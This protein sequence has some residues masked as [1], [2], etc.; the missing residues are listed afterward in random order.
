MG[1]LYPSSRDGQEEAGDRAR[2]VCEGSKVPVSEGA[3]TGV[4]NAFEDIKLGTLLARRV[5]KSTQGVW[6]TRPEPGTGFGVF[7]FTAG[8]PLFRADGRVV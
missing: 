8:A 4:T 3:K 7:I 6:Q 1:G 5:K 2:T